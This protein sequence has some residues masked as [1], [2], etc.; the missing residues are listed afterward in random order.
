MHLVTVVNNNNNNTTYYKTIW[1]V[2]SGNLSEKKIVQRPVAK[3]ANKTFK[4]AI[5]QSLATLLKRKLIYILY[6]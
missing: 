5:V 1:R 4:S 3:N 6:C 2:H